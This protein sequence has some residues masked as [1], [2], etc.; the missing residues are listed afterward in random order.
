MV[1]VDKRFCIGCGLCVQICPTQAISMVGRTTEID[2]ARCIDCKTCIS[3][4]PRGAI[5]ERTV[6]DVPEIKERLTRIHRRIREISFMLSR[7]E[8]KR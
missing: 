1:R 3:I 7:L 6:A 4:C 5:K 8:A 2:E